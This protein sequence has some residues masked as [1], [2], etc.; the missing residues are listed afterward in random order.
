MPKNVVGFIFCFLFLI[1]M[2]GCESGK[3]KTSEI[4][5]GDFYTCPMHPTVQSKSPGSCPVCNMSLIKV[6]HQ[7]SSHTLHKGNFITIEKNQQILAGILTDTV[8]F[9]T[10]GP[11]AT[12]L[13][14]VA[15][16][17]DQV[18]LVSSRVKGRLEKLYYK[19]SGAFI[20][21]GNPVYEIYSEQLL[22]D[23]HE[24]LVLAEQKRNHLSSNGLLDGLFSASRNKLFL[25]GLSK[26]QI[27]ELE[28]SRMASPTV[29][30]YSEDDGYVAEVFFKEGSFLEVGNVVLKLTSLTHVLIDAQVYGDE[31]ETVKRSSHFQV[32]SETFPGHVFNARL[33]VSNPELAEGRKWQ[34][35]RLRVDNSGNKLIPGMMV[36]VSPRQ[37]TRTVLAV[38]KSSVLMEK[39]KTV[40]VKADDKTF[41]QKMVETGEE[42]QKWIEILSGLGKGEIIVTE[43]AYLISSEYSLKKGSGNRHE[44]E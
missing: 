5:E 25:W 33:V 29:T 17:E 40:W 24:F 11:S 4:N 10:I 20:R 7:S 15:F 43:G 14:T 12:I 13:G 27:E 3:V 9:R 44:H 31:M 39:M 38:P 8:G 26:S 21:K 32:L 22:S 34:L 18:R 19:T 28:K 2:P 35:L 41:E 30:F 6:E 16:D 42:S 36:Y 23:E 1:S 37:A